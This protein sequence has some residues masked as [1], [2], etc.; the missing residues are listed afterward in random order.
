MIPARPE[1]GQTWI[2]TYPD[3]TTQMRWVR[4]VFLYVVVPGD[5]VKWSVD[6]SGDE[7]GESDCL[8]ATSTEWL[9]WACEAELQP[10]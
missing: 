4:R 6:Y 1:P 3:G 9:R 2:K 10:G 5:D 8:S 7:T